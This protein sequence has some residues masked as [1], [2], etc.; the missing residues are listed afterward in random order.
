MEEINGVNFEIKNKEV[1]GEILRTLIYYPDLNI[2]VDIPH[3]MPKNIEDIKLGIYN[4]FQSE[5]RRIEAEKLNVEILSK[6]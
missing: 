5:Q 4:R 1:Q 3:F 2:E 6:L